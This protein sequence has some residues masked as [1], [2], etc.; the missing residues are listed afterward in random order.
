MEQRTI[1]LPTDGMTVTWDKAGA[2][3]SGWVDSLDARRA[4]KTLLAP[5][6]ILTWTSA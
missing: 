6:P 2:A 5:Q 1:W 4:G 3:F